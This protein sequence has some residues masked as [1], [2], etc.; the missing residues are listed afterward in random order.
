MDSADKEG[1]PRELQCSYTFPCETVSFAT[2]SDAARRY[3]TESIKKSCLININY[4]GGI[5]ADD[6][7][8]DKGSAKKQYSAPPEY[9]EKRKQERERRRSETGLRQK[10]KKGGRKSETTTEVGISR[11]LQ[12]FLRIYS[13]YSFRILQ[14]RQGKVRTRIPTSMTPEIKVLELRMDAGQ[15]SK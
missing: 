15:K 6:A 13:R 5:V 4:T 14:H 9:L 10:F 2:G 3:I 8:A 1:D 12:L 7:L 11:V